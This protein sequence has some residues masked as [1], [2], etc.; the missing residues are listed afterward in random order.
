M[1]IPNGINWLLH[2]NM[3]TISN[4]KPNTTYEYT[5]GAAC[6][7]GKYTHSTIQE[8][9]TMARDEIAFDRLWDQT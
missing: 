3:H 2:G 6:D 7:L 8:F 4:L 9:T 1:P 5:V